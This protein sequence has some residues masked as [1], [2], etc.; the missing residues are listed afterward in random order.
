MDA[1]CLELAQLCSQ[2]VDYQKNGVRVDIK[3]APHRLFP[4]RPD[5]KKG[6]VDNP[7][8]NDFYIS[9]KTLGVLYRAI[10]IPESSTGERH[11]VSPTPLEQHPIYKALK[12]EIDRYVLNSTL[13]GSTTVKSNG[14]GKSRIEL[15]RT[16]YVDELRFICMTH[17]LSDHPGSALTEEEIVVGTILAQSSQHR[18]RMERIYHMRAQTCVLV[19]RIKGKML[20]EHP[21]MASV[22]ELKRGLTMAWMAWQDSLELISKSD[23]SSS[24]SSDF[25]LHS[26]GFIAL[27]IIFQCLACLDSPRNVELV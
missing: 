5:F 6:E 26:F 16:E 21:H 20:P 17:C 13:N 25:G 15:L 1:G 23:G 7:Q 12:P 3:N 8:G 19:E 2:A 9:E 10:D 14:S 18:W 4:E 11:F 24:S 27:D 22:E